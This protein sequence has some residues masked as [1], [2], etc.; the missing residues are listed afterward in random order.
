MAVIEKAKKRNWKSSITRTL[1]DT[2]KIKNGNVLLTVELM[3]RSLYINLYIVITIVLGY[4]WIYIGTPYSKNLFILIWIGLFLL[5]L[6]ILFVQNL[7]RKDKDI[8]IYRWRYKPWQ[9]LKYNENRILFIIN[10][11]LP[12]V[13][14][15]V[16]LV[17]LLLDFI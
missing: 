8:F 13:F 4:L 15:F 1:V 14:I 10:N 3:T 11:V 12:P 5:N 6:Q 16:F 9:I 17:A 7:L 2:H